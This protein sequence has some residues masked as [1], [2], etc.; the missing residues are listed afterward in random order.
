VSEL[1]D[2][3]VSVLVSC[4]CYKLVAEAW[5]QFRNQEEGEHLPLEAV[6]RKLVKTEQAEKT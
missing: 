5:G 1:E 2:F 4:Y 6:A 3:C